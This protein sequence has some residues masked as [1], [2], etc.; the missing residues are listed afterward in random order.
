[1]YTLKPGDLIV[2]DGDGSGKWLH[3]V[4]QVTDA[5]V[6]LIQ[7]DIVAG[8]DGIGHKYICSWTVDSAAQFLKDGTWT[9]L[10]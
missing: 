10:C 6:T 5:E 2:T 7:H 8:I 3:L 9:I 4:L 1:M